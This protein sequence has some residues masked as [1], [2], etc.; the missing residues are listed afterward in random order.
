M[1]FIN[2]LIVLSLLS[3]LS[4][5]KKEEKVEI[6]IDDVIETQMLESYKKGLKA[7]DEGDALYAARH[8]TDAELLFPQSEWAP[9]SLLMAAYS[10]YSQDY[11][12]D[13]IAELE[14]F[15][16]TY[17]Q[18]NRLDYAYFLLA[19]CYYEK[20]IDE[21]KDLEPLI[22]AK[23]TFKFVIQEYPNTDFALDAKFKLNLIDETLAGKE[24]YIGRY[25]IKKEKWIAAINRFKY[26][27]DNYNS[28]IYIEEA[29]HRLVEL[30]YKIG[31]IEESKK[32]AAVLGYNYQSG[33]WYEVSYQI[34][35][36]EFEPK[37]NS[38]KPKK[39]NFIFKKFKNLFEN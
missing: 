15:I 33:E 20:I 5:T 2:I 7:L 21:K 3:F 25:Y 27:V 24:M 31:L 1:K 38:I 23:E 39:G 17:P 16:K 29:L 35:N 36:K 18:S 12:A 30:H 13:A 11:F 28:T 10:Y 22:K 9:K 8:F 37:D 19:T 34:F 32:Y 26:V 4:C 14:R 6:I